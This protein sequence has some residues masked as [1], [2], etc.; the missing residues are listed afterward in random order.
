MLSL[1]STKRIWSDFAGDSN[2]GVL[3][4]ILVSLPQVPAKVTN[5][6]CK[7]FLLPSD[8]DYHV[9][10][11]DP[12]LDNKRVI[13]HMILYGC[14]GNATVEDEPFNC[15]MGQ[16]NCQDMLLGWTVGE[17]GTVCM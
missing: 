12:I 17:E 15:I 6:Y 9:I 2:L 10:A 5:Y 8:G 4:G 11:S 13:H 14:K 3:F 7:T 1:V 16:T